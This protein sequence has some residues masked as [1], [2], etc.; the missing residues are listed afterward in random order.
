MTGSP[1]ECDSQGCLDGFWGP[2]SRSS[3]SSASRLYMTSRASL[4]IHQPPGSS[5][6]H[7]QGTFKVYGHL[8][9]ALLSTN[10]PTSCCSSEQRPVEG[11]LLTLLPLFG[12]FQEEPTCPKDLVSNLTAWL[13][14]MSSQGAQWARDALIL[15]PCDLWKVMRGRTIWVVGDSMTEVSR[16]H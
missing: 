8:A 3:S 14:E 11:L 15:Q 16:P 7:V 10:N 5:W 13:R 6:T 2:R 12:R 1:E 4:V 9:N